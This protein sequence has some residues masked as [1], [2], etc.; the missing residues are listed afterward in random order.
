MCKFVET[1]FTVKQYI[2]GLTLSE[3]DYGVLEEYIVSGNL[4]VI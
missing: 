2:C 3:G 1:T 4:Y